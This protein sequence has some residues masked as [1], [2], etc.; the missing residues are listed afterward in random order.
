VLLA[1]S[2]A[3]VTAAAIV[4]RLSCTGCA[5]VS[6]WTWCGVGL[7]MVFVPDALAINW[8]TYRVTPACALCCFVA[9]TY[10]TRRYAF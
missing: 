3:T 10:T 4:T 7:L 9:L 5:Q 2:A 6:L 8:K 1:G